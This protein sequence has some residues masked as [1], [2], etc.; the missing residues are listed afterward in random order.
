M[1]I[2]ANDPNCECAGVFRRKEM[3]WLTVYQ[4][5]LQE[6][7]QLAQQKERA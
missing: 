1:F 2:K 4:H 3:T 7:W 5:M 6:K